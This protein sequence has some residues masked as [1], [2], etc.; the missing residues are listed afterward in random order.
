[1]KLI[2]TLMTL[3]ITSSLFAGVGES[4]T[5]ENQLLNMTD[6]QWSNLEKSIANNELS[7]SFVEE[8][9]F[10]AEIKTLHERYAVSF[11]RQG[12]LCRVYDLTFPHLKLLFTKN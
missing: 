12:Q 9:C 4:L 6:K 5:L 2:L 8:K 3:F 7:S 1:M 10:D 11:D